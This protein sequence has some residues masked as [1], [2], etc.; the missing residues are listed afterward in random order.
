MPITS[1]NSIGAG[2]MDGSPVYPA[3]VKGEWVQCHAD[4]E[5]ASSLGTAGCAIS[6]GSSSVIPLRISGAG[7]RVLIR[8]RYA[9]GATVTTSPVVKVWVVDSDP[10]ITRNAAGTI[11]S[12]AWATDG[13]VQYMRIDNQDNSAAGIT[14]TLDSTNDQTDATYKYSDPVSLTGL[15]LQGGSW[16]LVTVATQANVNSGTV[17]IYA[18]LLN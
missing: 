17:P 2:V 3:S 18:R 15:D 6:E 12:V 9:T 11:T 13:T 7:T 14:V 1:I 5:Q 8:A 4:S 10:T 16:L